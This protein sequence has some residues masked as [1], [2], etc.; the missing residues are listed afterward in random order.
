[1]QL[2]ILISSSF[3]LVFISSIKANSGINTFVIQ[4]NLATG[5]YYINIEKGSRSTNV[6]EYIKV[7][8]NFKSK[9]DLVSNNV[10]FSVPRLCLEL[11]FINYISV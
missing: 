10:A 8:L 3:S 2:F 1:M 6:L 4:Q 11:I 9:R 7:A 5:I